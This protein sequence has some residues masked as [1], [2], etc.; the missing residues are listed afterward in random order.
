ML[1]PVINSTL[2]LKYKDVKKIILIAFAL[3]VCQASQAQSRKHASNFSLFQQYYNPAFT[4]FQGSVVKSY[5]RNQ[6]AGFDGAPKTFFISGEVNLADYQRGAAPLM[7]DGAAVAK[8]GIQHSVGLS[9]LHDTFGPFVE[10]QISASY[11]SLINLTEKV[12]LQAGAAITYHAQML[13]GNKLT[14]DEA[15]DPLLQNYMNRTS[16]SGRMDFNIGVALSGQDFYAGY[17]MQ[18]IRGG[19]GG[20]KNDFFRNN[21]KM[22]YILQGGYRKAVSDKIGLVFNGLVRFDDQLKETLEGQV[23]GVFFNTAWLGLGYRHSLAYSLNVGF[24]MKQIQIGYAYEI[25]T[26]DA[27]MTGSSTN[28]LMITYDLKKIIHQKLTRQISIW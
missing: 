3:F 16:R 17:S 23:K 21:S 4:G 19:L 27:Q 13:D 10:N 2:A 11:R 24:R 28:E 6:W 8:T 5:Y 26:G 15:N 9:V 20:S 1:K 12:R 25:P 7:E 22:H 14:S 18:N